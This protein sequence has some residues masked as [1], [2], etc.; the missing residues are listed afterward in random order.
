MKE[1]K[2]IFIEKPMPSKFKIKTNTFKVMLS[3]AIYVDILAI[4]Y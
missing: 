1:E 2:Q 4:K 3:G